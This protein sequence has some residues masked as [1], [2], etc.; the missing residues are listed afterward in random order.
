MYGKYDD[1]TALDFL[2]AQVD[3]EYRL[4]WDTH[5]VKLR[6][7]DTERATRSD[8]IYWETKWPVCIL[9]FLKFKLFN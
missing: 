7:L 9:T 5:A 1:V 4:A 2:E 8:V 6:T 3:L